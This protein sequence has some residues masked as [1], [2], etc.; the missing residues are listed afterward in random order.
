MANRRIP[1][2]DPGTAARFAALVPAGPG[3]VVRSLFGQ[4]AAFHRGNLFLGVFGDAIF[5]RLDPDDRAAA[6]GSAGGRPFEPMPGRPMREYVVL[7]ERALAHPS[8]AAD[9]VAR[10]LRYAQT[11]PEK[12]GAP[13]RRG[14]GGAAAGAA[15]ARP[16]QRPTGPGRSSSAG[17]SS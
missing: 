12:R 3:T 2:P 16:R 17:R 6:M 8:E 15:P 13:A 14:A 1:R 10:A 11:L 5:V 9:W 4:P 7:P